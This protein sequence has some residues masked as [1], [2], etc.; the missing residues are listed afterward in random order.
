MRYFIT[1]FIVKCFSKSLERMKLILPVPC[2]SNLRQ[3][4]STKLEMTTISSFSISSYINILVLT[5]NSSS[6]EGRVKPW[7]NETQV[8]A[9]HRKSTQVLTCEDLRSLAIGWPN[10]T[11]VERKSFAKVAEFLFFCFFFF[12]NLLANLMPLFEQESQTISR[13]SRFP[14]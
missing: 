14:F 3:N 7:P 10:A 9:S 4:S 2:S 13:L 5:K 1:I 12:L 11:Q 8:I 6:E